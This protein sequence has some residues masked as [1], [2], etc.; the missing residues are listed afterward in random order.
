MPLVARR[1][2]SGVDLKCEAHAVPGPR[3]GRR[4][5]TFFFAR[6]PLTPQRHTA[7]RMDLWAALGPR[8]IRRVPRGRVPQGGR[9]FDTMNARAD[10]RGECS[11]SGAGKTQTLC[12]VAAQV[13]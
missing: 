10:G 13:F 11:F 3:T 1:A 6:P 9:V 8:I 12:L 7:T 2:T 5:A 4:M